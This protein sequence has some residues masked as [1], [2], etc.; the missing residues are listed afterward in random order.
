MGVLWRNYRSLQRRVWVRPLRDCDTYQMSV[1][2]EVLSAFT[3]NEPYQLK[4]HKLHLRSYTL[5][6][7]LSSF[8]FS[9]MLIQ[10][11][12]SLPE[13]LTLPSLLLSSLSI[14]ISTVNFYCILDWW[15]A[16]RIEKS[17]IEQL[18]T[19][20]HTCWSCSLKH[21]CFHCGF[22]LDKCND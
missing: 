7:W 15:K 9:F 3:G 19:R 20:R 22:T 6:T 16:A 1:A 11:V 21:K 17:Y 18:L 10:Y 2:T 4:I 14:C 13:P 8:G 5:L 12:K